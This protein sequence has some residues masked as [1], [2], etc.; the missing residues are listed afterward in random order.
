MN[1]LQEGFINVAVLFGGDSVEHEVSIISAVQ[2]MASMDKTKYNIIPV[3]IAKNGRFY[4]S[5]SCWILTL[6]AAITRWRSF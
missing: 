6:F 3:Y 2:A 1:N 4:T 5:Q